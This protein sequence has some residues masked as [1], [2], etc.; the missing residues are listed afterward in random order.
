MINKPKNILLGAGLIVV[1]SSASPSFAIPLL[2]NADGSFGNVV[3]PSGAGQSS[4]LPLALPFTLNY[5]GNSYNS[6]YVNNNGSVTFGRGT[7]GALTTETIP[8][9]REILNPPMIAPFWSA[10]TT[11]CDNCGDVYMGSPNEDTAIFTWN[12]IGSW[13]SPLANPPQST[14]DFQLVLR[15]RAGDTGVEGDFDAEFRYNRLD[16][17]YSYGDGPGTERPGQAGFDSGSGVDFIRLPGSQ[18]ELVQELQNT[19]NVS[20]NTPGLWS[21]A[22]RNGTRPGETA[23]NPLMPVITDTGFEFEFVVEAD[24]QVFIDPVIAIGYDYVVTSGPNFASV[25]LPNIGDDIY[26]LWLWNGTEYV[27]SGTKITAGDEYF[28]GIGGV[29]RFRIMGIEIDA[30]LDPTDAT[31]FVTGLTFVD[32]GIISMTQSAVTFETDAD[33]VAPVP[34]PASLALMGLGLIGLVASR[35]QRKR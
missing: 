21:L 18:T 22:F 7:S 28:L 3:V 14:N 31:A 16:W 24:E 27:D 13:R 20:P 5:F 26:D 32:S 1:L 35:R 25:V 19:S 23:D 34:A 30:M 9:R 12:N 33:D 11:D 8:A 17:L 29:D 10:G 4:Y 15:N 6:L 2:T